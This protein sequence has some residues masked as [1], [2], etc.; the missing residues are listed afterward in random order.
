[1]SQSL[2]NDKCKKAQSE[3]ASAHVFNPSEFARNLQKSLNESVQQAEDVQEMRLNEL[4]LC[5]R[6]KEEK[7]NEKS[8]IVYMISFFLSFLESC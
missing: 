8:Y 3:T 6:Q 5:G 4:K 7:K 2:Q 1:M